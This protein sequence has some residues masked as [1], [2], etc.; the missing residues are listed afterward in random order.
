MALFDISNHVL[1]GGRPR[2]KEIVAWLTENVGEYYGNGDDPV[3]HV[4][5]GWE[6]LYHRDVDWEEN[7]ITNWVLDITDDAKSAHFALKWI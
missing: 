2:I 6:I 1:D 7:Y 5:L 3:I 4:G